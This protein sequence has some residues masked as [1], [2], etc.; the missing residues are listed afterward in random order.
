MWGE[1]FQNLF[2]YSG[3]GKTKFLLGKLKMVNE[4][5][6]ER[7]Y[8]ENGEVGF[9][10]FYEDAITSHL[11]TVWSDREYFE[12]EGVKM[13]AFG[14]LHIIAGLIEVLLMITAPVWIPLKNFRKAKKASKSYK[15]WLENGETE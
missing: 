12:I 4:K 9:W 8:E 7:I 3:L 15:E 2:T 5:I 11:D 13:V 14:I 6:A 1:F 10:Y